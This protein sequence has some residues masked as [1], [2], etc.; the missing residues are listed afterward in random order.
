MYMKTITKILIILIALLV[1][2]FAVHTINSKT[3]QPES[4]TNNATS[5]NPDF[6][7]NKEPVIE[8]T[9]S[10]AS[11]DIIQVELPYPGAVTGK[12]FT[13]IGKAR[14]YWF[15]EASF[16]VELRSMDGNILGGGVATAVGDWMTEDF[17]PFTAEMQTPSA[18]IGP[19]I[20]ILKKDNPSGES[21]NEASV[22]FPITI[23][24]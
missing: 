10:N 6:D 2:W 24:Y 19:A 15:F 18:F 16:P 9:Y 21:Q 8:P 20:L 11:A 3:S 12:E 5:T 23:E 22:S 14:G 7:P 4:P 17:V 1:I 13:I